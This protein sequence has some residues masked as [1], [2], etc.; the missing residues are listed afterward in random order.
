MQGNE[1]DLMLAFLGFGM[2]AVFMVLIM[3]RVLSAI[4]ALILVPIVFGLFAGHHLDMSMM[5]IEGFASLAPTAVTLLFAVLYFSIML[6]AG[7]FDPVVDKAVRFAK[8]DPLRVTL[9]TTAVAALISLDGDGATTAIITISAFL[10]IYRRLGMN[11][12]YLAVLLGSANAVVNITPWGGPALRAATALKVDIGEVFVPLIP[13]MFMG[14]LATFS[15]AW[16][17]GLRERKRLGI[18]EIDEG[19]FDSVFQR[20][21]GVARPRLLWVNFILTISILA[22]AITQIIPLPVAFMI[23]LSLALIVNYPCVKQ[24]RERIAAHAENVLP[25]ALLIF[26]AAVFV[27]ILDGTK[28]V[29]AMGNGLLA[30]IPE[31]VGPYFGS[32]IAL[33]SAPL[34]FV[35]SNDAYYFGIVPV[36]A[37]AASQ[38]GVTPTEV[39][40]ASLLGVT[41]HALSPLIAAIY[42]VAG[43][44]D[45]EVG[46][47]Q[48]VALPFA[49]FVFLV[50]VLTAGLVG[51]I[52]FVV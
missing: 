26:A 3:T 9:A 27:G 48:R 38:Y 49:I 6:D 20:E 28:M 22:C 21:E 10:P 18:V 5:A 16:F 47:L 32:I 42:L 19:M 40:R 41:V 29:D 51:A 2:I 4:V 43:L 50:M 15:V 31:S 52:P 24:Q 39:A 34:T 30:I 13:V 23:G 1:T 37:E 25:I 33:T 17:L 36:L 45:V 44:L 11:P 7:L 46:D 35:M 12:L 8:G 14:M